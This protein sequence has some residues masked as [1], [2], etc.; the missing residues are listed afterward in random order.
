MPPRGRLVLAFLSRPLVW[1]FLAAGA[2]A[3]LGESLDI[4]A[5][6]WLSVAVAALLLGLAAGC[7]R[8]WQ[9]AGIALAFLLGAAGLAAWSARLA[10]VPP[11]GDI[12]EWCGRHAI[13]EGTVASDPEQVG[14]PPDL[15]WRFLLVC[16]RVEDAG[17]V[18]AASGRLAVTA[19]RPP[20]FGARLLVPGI[21]RAPRGRSNPGGFSAAAY[22][23]RRGVFALM[24]ESRPGWRAVGGPGPSGVRGA[25]DRFCFR[26]RRGNERFLAPKAAYLV[27]S[28]VLGAQA[29]P[30]GVDDDAIRDDFR[31][32]GTIHI[33]VVSGTQVTLLLLPIVWF[34]RRWLWLRRATALLAIPACVAYAAATG[35]E[36]SILR[37]ACAGILLSLALSLRR[38]ADFLNVLGF[39]GLCL[40]AINPLFIGDPGFLLSFAAVWGVAQLGPV[41]YEALRRAVPSAEGTSPPSLRGWKGL[42]ARAQ[43]WSLMLLA[44]SVAAYLVLTPIIACLKGSA[45]PVSIAANLP[46]V[47]LAGLLLYA[48]VT[49]SISA[50]VAH[51][52]QLL[53]RAVDVLAL[54]LLK[55]VHWFGALPTGHGSVYPLP[56]ALLVLV[57]A[58]L[59]LAAAR[60]RARLRSALLCA[61]GALLLTEIG[62]R[63]PAPAPGCPE[64][65][66]IDVGQGDSTLVRLPDGRTMLV[67]AGGHPRSSFDVGERVVAPTLRALRISRLDLV[68]ATH[69]HD[70]H[71]GGMAA[72]VEDEPVGLFVDSGQT[73]GTAA[74]RRLLL[75]LRERGVPFRL[76]H[77]GERFR[78]GEALVEVLG[79]PRPFLH[80]TRSDLN[81]NSKRAVTARVSGYRHRSS[82]AWKPPASCSCVRP[83]SVPC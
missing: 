50:A 7:V 4:S 65:T 8:R 45:A 13:V 26:V 27:N 2:G 48:G 55:C 76:A 68:V 73:A 83:D 78:F 25:I 63:C 61:A 72:V 44:A 74:Q 1:A 35:A 53:S 64:L 3:A 54:A 21:P 60:G 81:S 59:V 51:P 22:W 37:A 16:R 62:I 10:S 17:G 32:S 66:F 23:R 82:C 52:P 6:L 5:A 11:A 77:A 69:P 20:E 36:A 80:G 79:P 29:P 38:D 41:F 71:I 12:A 75:A 31:N 9:G 56:I 18:A 67:D 43:Q 24:R 34:C 40:L 47:T 15:R 42:A 30:A 33:L 39:A 19:K 58:L 28:L 49:H 46:A 70:D 57:F 14:T